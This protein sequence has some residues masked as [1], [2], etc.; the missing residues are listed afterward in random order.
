MACA[1]FSTPQEQIVADEELISR[2][3]TIVLATVIKAE[4]TE[5]NQNSVRFHFTKVRTL[6]GDS[7]QHFTIDGDSAAHGDP[8]DDF[9]GHSKPSFWESGGGRSWHDTDCAIHPTFA[10]G[11]TFLIFLD[12]PYHRKSFELILR[13]PD[14]APEVQDKWLKW[15]E[16]HI[17]D[18]PPK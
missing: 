11:G 16:S 9:Y 8:L 10:V 15:V 18:N 2:T 12:K 5:D 17:R 3:K 1:C 13:S 4:L 6:K 7:P 14:A